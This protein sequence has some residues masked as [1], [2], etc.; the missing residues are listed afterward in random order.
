VPEARVLDRVQEVV[1]RRT[2]ETKRTASPGVAPDTFVP[3]FLDD[4]EELSLKRHRQ[5]AHLVEKERAS[6]RR[7]KSAVA[8]SDRAQRQVFALYVAAPASSTASTRCRRSWLISR[9]K[10]QM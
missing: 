2:N 5:F 1:M 9:R 8:R 4:A 10:S 3:A 7:S 6:I